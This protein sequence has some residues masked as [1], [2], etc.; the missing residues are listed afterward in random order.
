MTYHSRENRK[1]Y[2]PPML[3]NGDISFAP[4]KEGMLGYAAA[5]YQ[6][7]GM[8]AFDGIVVRSARRSA[9]C[10]SLQARLFPFGKFT[11]CEGSKISEW[12]QS[13]VKEK[14]FFESSCLYESGTEIVSR[15][16]IHP[17]LNIY[18]LE[19]TF[20]RTNGKKR[21]AYDI[22]LCGYNEEISRYMRVLYTGQQEDIGV[23]GFEMYGMEVFR[24]EIHV[25]VDAKCMITATDHG[26]RIM[27]EAA[28]GDKVS[29][30]Y[31]LEDD[32]GGCDYAARLKGYKSKIDMSGF[33][34]MLE[35]CSAHYRD[36][37]HPGFVRTSDDMLNRI[38]NTSLYSIKCNTTKY[39]IAVGF[40]NGSWDGRFFA[41]DE[42]T[43]Y[44]GLLGSNRLELARRVPSYRLKRC[45]D[46]AIT[47]ASD[48]QKRVYRRH[49]PFSLGSGRK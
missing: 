42:Y 1:S 45:L 27:F 16:F 9:L 4:D 3:S 34:G 35:E 20:V 2:F 23:I 10:H 13:L 18:A 32:M 17:E 11:F 41:F 47:R 6:Q 38:Y 14:G 25:C 39:S 22:A 33:S 12:S 46:S 7:D 28:E 8:I 30:Y 49:G 29:F 37:Y 44:L 24:G 5:D 36:F 15:G 40:N 48:C 21:F 19:K 31:Y 26:I 43:S